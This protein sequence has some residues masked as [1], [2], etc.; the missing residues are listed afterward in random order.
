MICTKV[1]DFLDKIMRQNKESEAPNVSLI[2][3]GGAS[4]AKFCGE[5]QVKI[6]RLTPF[7]AAAVGPTETFGGE[8]GLDVA[9][10]SSAA[11]R[12]S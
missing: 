4:P 10:T 5:S 2:A 3:P 7:L 11:R 8:P 9:A 12:R 1:A 6:F